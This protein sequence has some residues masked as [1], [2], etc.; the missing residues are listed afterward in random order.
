MRRHVAGFVVLAVS[1]AMIPASAQAPR[2]FKMVLIPGS[3]EIIMAVMERQQLLKK[4]NLEP[5]I[6]KLLSPAGVHLLIV[7]GK[8][9]IRLG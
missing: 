3:Q 4:H 6:Q 9:E 8:V 2:K 5:Q 1:L 7:E